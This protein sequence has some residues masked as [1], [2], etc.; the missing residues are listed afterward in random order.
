[1]GSH[2]PFR[3]SVSYVVMHILDVLTDGMIVE[4]MKLWLLHKIGEEHANEGT[5]SSE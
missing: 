5:G 3:A 4:F 2:S 1:M